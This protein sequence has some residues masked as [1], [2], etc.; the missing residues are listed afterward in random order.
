MLTFKRNIRRLVCGYFSPIQAARNC[1]VNDLN[2]V[3]V[4]DFGMTRYGCLSIGRMVI[5]ITA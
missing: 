2:V 3:K 1:L 5:G 4:S